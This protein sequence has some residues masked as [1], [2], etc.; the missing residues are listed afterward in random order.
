[1]TVMR[2]AQ[3][4]DGAGGFT[5]IPVELTKARGDVSIARGITVE[6]A[7]QRGFDVTHSIT[8]PNSIPIMVG[9]IIIVGERELRVAMIEQPN[10]TAGFY[11]ILAVE[12]SVVNP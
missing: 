9:D 6:R 11:T 10:A 12:V 1:M 5:H 3:H 8:V 2:K 4:P 7:K